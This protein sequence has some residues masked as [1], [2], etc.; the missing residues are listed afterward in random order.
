[1]KSLQ[2]SGLFGIYYRILNSLK[3]DLT[4][5]S[6]LTRSTEQ[7]PLNATQGWDNSKVVPEFLKALPCKIN[8]TGPD[9]NIF[10]AKE[11]VA[12]RQ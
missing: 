6:Y 5:H 11:Y 1:M 12:L 9:H 10:P 3:G 7:N 4:N 8:I 2:I